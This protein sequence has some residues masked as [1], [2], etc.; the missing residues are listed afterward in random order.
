[1]GEEANHANARAVH[2]E[3]RIK[4]AEMSSMPPSCSRQRLSS[5]VTDGNMRGKL[6]AKGCT[7]TRQGRRVNLRPTPHD[8]AVTGIRDGNNVQLL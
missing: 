4:G 5:C 7:S 2:A 8:T 6:S 1:V 3:T